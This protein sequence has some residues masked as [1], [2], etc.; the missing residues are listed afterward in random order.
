MKLHAFFLVIATVIAVTAAA[1]QLPTDYDRQDTDFLNYPHRFPAYVQ[2][3][4]PIAVELQAR[5]Q[6]IGVDS[7]KAGQIAEVQ[8]KSPNSGRAIFS[9]RAA[10]GDYIINAAARIKWSSFTNVYALNSYTNGHWLPDQLVE[11][12][13]F[14]CPP[15]QT[16]ITVQIAVTDDD[17]VVTVNGITLAIYTFRGSLT[18]DKVKTVQFTL[19]DGNASVKG[20]LEKLTV[21]F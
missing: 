16:T 13:P 1:A 12:F 5:V 6:S 4:E 15:V 11:G 7:L 10:N 19:D 20:V 9:L 8:Y 21:S 3:E 14:T 2:H 18:P 17:F